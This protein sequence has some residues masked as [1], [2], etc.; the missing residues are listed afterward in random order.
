MARIEE[1]IRAEQ[2]RLEAVLRAAYDA[3]REDAKR[4]MLAVL[5]GEATEYGRL[6]A[7]E[8]GDRK[9]A[10]KGL[11]RRLV[12]RVLADM[13]LIGSTPQSIAEAAVTE[14][15]KMIAV[16]SIRGELRKG[17]EEGRYR[18]ERGYWYLT[19]E[20][21]KRFSGRGVPSVLD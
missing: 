1:I 18:E 7:S 8:E 4:D 11:P 5:S 9:R 17:E 6:A 21:L 14:H 3:G 20:E 15:E 19:P 10:P 16:S 12:T 13:D 2:K